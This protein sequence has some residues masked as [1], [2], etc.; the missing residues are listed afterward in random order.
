MELTVIMLDIDD[1]K[2]V[3]DTYG[4]LVVISYRNNR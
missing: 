4:H 3:N 1:F 2:P